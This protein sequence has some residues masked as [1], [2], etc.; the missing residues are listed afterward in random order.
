MMRDDGGLCKHFFVVV[1]AF[2]GPAVTAGWPGGGEKIRQRTWNPPDR[3]R[4]CDQRSRT[5]RPRWTLPDTQTC[6]TR[7]PSR[8]ARVDL[9]RPRPRLL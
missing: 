7:P 3:A 8:A 4:K 5:R 9:G 1:A 6:P 2:S